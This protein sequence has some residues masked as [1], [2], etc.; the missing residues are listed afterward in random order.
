MTLSSLLCMRII[1]LLWKIFLSHEISLVIIFS[2]SVLWHSENSNWKSGKQLFYFTP[3]CLLLI[4]DKYKF[5]LICSFKGNETVLEDI[6]I[7]LN[8]N[9]NNS[10]KLFV[11]Q[12]STKQRHEVHHNKTTKNDLS[13]RGRFYFTSLQHVPA[14]YFANM[15]K[16]INIVMEVQ[17]KFI[18]SFD[19]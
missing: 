17:N 16:W 14:L 3:Q 9:N 12:I 8:N 5:P 15:S 19:K 6:S 7:T 18:E 11:Q 1:F 13:T 4:Y 2:A 10:N